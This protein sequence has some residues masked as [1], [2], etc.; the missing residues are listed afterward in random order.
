MPNRD[1]VLQERLTQIAEGTAGGLTFDATTTQQVAAD[2]DV[3]LARSRNPVYVFRHYSDDGVRHTSV[4]FTLSLNGQGRPATR[5]EALGKSLA[6]SDGALFDL[7]PFLLVYD[8][9]GE[10]LL[11]VPAIDLFDAFAT[12]V[13]STDLPYVDTASF[14]LS[15]NFAAQSLSMYAELR[16]PAVW[17]TSTDGDSLTWQNLNSFLDRVVRSTQAKRGEIPRIVSAVRARLEARPPE[18]SADGQAGSALH[19]ESAAGALHS[20]IANVSVAPRLWRMLLAAIDSGPAAILVGPPGTGKSALV[21]QAVNAIDARER[22]AGHVGLNAPLW[23]TPDES[24]TA[25]ELIGGETVDGGEIVFR[26]GWVLRAI[27]EDRWLVLDEANRGDLDRIFGALLTWLSGGSVTVG[28]ESAAAD[29]AFIELGWC[30]G[31]SRV[32]RL[33]G[34]DGTRGT[35]RYLAGSSWKLLATYNALDAQRVFRLGAALGRRFSRVPVPPIDPAAFSAVLA[36]QA[37]DLDPAALHALTGLYTAHFESE[38]TRLGPAMF[39]AM[40]RYLRVTLGAVQSPRDSAHSDDTA[41]RSLAIADAEAMDGGIVGSENLAASDPPER[42]QMEV[43]DVPRADVA[44]AVAEAYI[45]NLGTMLAQLETTDFETLANRIRA[46]GGLSA[47][48]VEWVGAMLH[49]LA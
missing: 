8:N 24:W 22:S 32:E 21:T 29:A 30:E 18:L 34:E 6:S 41:V 33:D 10:R 11:A 5:V 9:V 27:A 26:P 35:V 15:P 25:R 1:V 49:N 16:P 12:H 7:N 43:P 31:P 19:W 37:E 17:A 23:A 45:L 13:E 44:A 14:S 36:T 47:E 3:D 2:F 40:C 38:A 39:L 4:A 48:E 20:E 42:G 46:S 28:V